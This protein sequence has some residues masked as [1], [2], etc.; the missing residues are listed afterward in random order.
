MARKPAAVFLLSFILVAFL[1]TSVVFGSD[2][3]IKPFQDR[4]SFPARFAPVYGFA[5]AEK[6]AFAAPKGAD[7]VALGEISSASIGTQVGTTSYDYQHN[8]SMGHQVEHRGTSYVHFDWMYQTGF[9]LGVGRGIAVQSYNLTD[10]DLEFP[11][12]KLATTDYGGYCSMDA[13]QNL[14]AIPGGHEGNDADSQRPRT[15]FDFCATGPFGLFTGDAPTDV[16]GWYANN[17]AGPTNQN[18]WP[19]IEYQIGTEEVIHMVTN[20]SGGAAGDPATCSYNRRVGPY[21]ASLG[22][23]SPQVIIDTVMNINCVV[24]ASQTSDKVAIA[25]NRPVTYLGRGVDELGPWNQMENDIWYAISDVQGRDWVDSCV[26]PRTSIAHKILTNPGYWKGGNITN[27]AWNSDWKAY[28]NI[29]ALITSDNNLHVIW[30]CRQWTDT[31]S[32]F[33]RSSAI[34]HWSEDHPVIRTVAKA[35]WYTGGLC[36]GHTWGSDVDKESISE[37][38]GKLYVLF[39]QFGND[40]APCTDYSANKKVMNGEL[41]MTVSGDNGVNWDRPQNLTNS[42]SPLCADGSCESDNWAT[43][44]RFGRTEVCG[45]L[46]GQKVLDVIYVNDKSAGGAIQTESGIWTTN[47]VKWFPTVCRAVVPEPLYADDAGPGYGEPFSDVPL[48]I[49]PGGD[50]M[51]TLKMENMGLLANNWSISTNP[52][53]TWITANPPSGSIPCCGGT[54]D[55][56]ITFSTPAGAL[57]PSYYKDTIVVT[58]QAVGAPRKIRVG[59]IVAS[60][61][62]YPKSA[63]LA[64]ACKKIKVWNTGDMVNNAPGQ[65]LD[66]TPNDCDTFN[67]QVTSNIYLYDG[68]PI[69]CR[70]KGADTLRFMAY[71]KIFTDDDAL[72]PLSPLFVDTM[73]PVYSYATSEFCTADSAIGMQV[74]YYVPKDDDT[75]EFIMVVDRFW[76]KTNVQLNGVLL[77]EF[78]DWDVPSDS[79]SRNASGYDAGL[80]VIWQQGAEY[81]DTTEDLCPQQETDRYAAIVVDSG[82]TPK[83]AMT[84]DNA[85]YIYSSGPYGGTAPMPKG[86]TYKLM[87][88]KTGYIKWEDRVPAPPAD[89]AKT[90]LSM[91]LTYGEYNLPAYNAVNCSTIV[92][93]KYLYTT[94]SGTPN[95]TNLKA[96]MLAWKRQNLYP[97]KAVSDSLPKATNWHNISKTY[98]PTSTPVGQIFRQLPDTTK[99][100]TVLTWAY[101]AAPVGTLSA[102]DS[103]AFK[104]NPGKQGVLWVGPTLKLRSWWG[105]GPVYL[106]GVLP[107]N[108]TVND[109]TAPWGSWWQEISPNYGR[110]HRILAWFDTNPDGKLDSSDYV[111]LQRNIVPW[112]WWWWS[113]YHV[114]GL[115]TDIITKALTCCDKPGDANND[116]A[117]NVGDA[118]YVI[119]YVF[120]S[121]PVPPCKCEGDAN[122]DNAINVGDAVY[123]INYVFK[124]GPVPICNLANP[125]CQ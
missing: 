45:A 34:F 102:G 25:W 88:E 84:I 39:T 4:A 54:Q 6:G 87:K 67:N 111:I 120:K 15:Y 57:N 81:N 80:G 75:C 35:Q 44:A 82:F 92:F 94:K 105:F 38:D 93:V 97:Q 122:G 53:A 74:E 31:T 11:T 85:T 5:G 125:I 104:K 41:Y 3:P 118:V 8:C 59:L 27:Y 114:E 89:S 121:G 76:N 36:Y 119:N 61:F 51:I 108:P 79:G 43:M 50:T 60:D 9:V 109:I 71:S 40:A 49:A 30:G 58:H 110:F 103:L 66:F 22:V 12:V 32:V 113:I 100:D 14:C 29:G 98:R 73:N 83:N 68:S 1:A 96:K 78:I 33:R 46:I 70:L 116:N 107:P 72:R 19:L 90:D 17:G 2:K 124:S 52:V 28:C 77:G 115:Y 91:L 47:P 20:E 123:V 62:D 55:V 18:L 64:T 69:V 16:F 42:P 101:D 56:D 24:T 86:A 95:W 13:A 112:W 117:V 21:G 106:E 65:A 63:V 7:Q 10:C 23:W 99:Q 48:R 37:C 26:S